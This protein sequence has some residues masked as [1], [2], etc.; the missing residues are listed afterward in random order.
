MCGIAGFYTNNNLFQS[1]EI[2]KM[3]KAI[4]HRGFNAEGFFTDKGVSLGH[5]RLSIID[6]SDNSNQPI[7]DEE[8]NLVMVFNGEIYNFKELAEQLNLSVKSDTQLLLHAFKK[9][10]VSFVNKLN[11]MFAIAIYN[12]EQ[13]KMYLFRDRVG[14]K[15]LFYYYKNGQLAFASEL[16]ALMQLTYINQNKVFNKPLVAEFLQLGYIPEPYTIYKDIYKFPK[17]SY[18]EFTNGELTIKPYWELKK[19]ISSDII[20]DEIEAKQHL[21]ELLESS[22][23][24]RLMSDVPYGS[25]L[26]GGVD[27]SLVSAIAQKVSNKQISTFSIGFE[28]SKFNETTYSQAVAKHIDS[29]H[30]E[31]ILTEKD[32]LNGLSD[33]FSLYDEPFADTSA[34]PSMLVAKMA[35]QN[36]TMTLSGDG[37]DELFY[38]YGAY[39]WAGRLNSPL[40][41]L[42]RGL[43]RMALKNGNSRLKR[44]SHL[45][46]FERNQNIQKHIFS[47]E[48]YFFS[49]KEL[50][51]FLC[52]GEGSGNVA[53]FS[54]DNKARKLTPIEQQA[55][56][57]LNYYL[58]DDLLVKVDRATMFNSLETRVPILDHRIVEFALNLDSKLKLNG[59]EGKYLLK[60]VL[61][62]Y[63][64]KEIFDRPKWGFSIPL[65]R[66]LQNELNFLIKEYLSERVVNNAQ[67]VNYNYVLS[68]TKQFLSG[69]HDYL[70]NRV[71]LLICLHKWYSDNMC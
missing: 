68:L 21:K 7:S 5:R 15:P 71:W 34:I 25:F 63:V 26:S 44:V 2:K 13:N 69:T 37:G 18:A 46:D 48:Q 20:T 50:R 53:N 27:S 3:T 57:D 43:I 11:G 42:N 24:Y 52:D 10:G 28:D 40:V 22:V 39:K 33:F 19:Q 16:K 64:P 49:V 23:K 8:G 31:Y 62:D 1:D 32:V 6:L 56:F 59:V 51:K 36:V 55:L 17:G 29:K 61:Y 47:Q 38:G 30:F 54:F 45:F 41:K 4:A 58:P 14:I 65:G 60:Q 12:R 9:W 70:Y 67:L 35:R 66:F